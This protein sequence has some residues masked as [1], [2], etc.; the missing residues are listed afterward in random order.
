VLQQ[1]RGWLL[2]RRP[3]ERQLLR[4]AEL[5]YGC[6]LHGPCSVRRCYRLPRHPTK[7][8]T[9]LPWGKLGTG[10]LSYQFQHSAVRLHSLGNRGSPRAMEAPM[11]PEGLTGPAFSMDSV[12]AGL[13]RSGGRDV[14]YARAL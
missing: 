10:S 11:N 9:P 13:S 12:G 6:R 14:R 1:G 7:V 3:V 5:R 4:P 8:H 2:L